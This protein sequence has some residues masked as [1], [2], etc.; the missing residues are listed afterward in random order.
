VLLQVICQDCG[1]DMALVQDDEV[2]KRIATGEYVNGSR[3]I[4]RKK[5]DGEQY[6]T[7]EEGIYGI[8]KKCAANARAIIDNGGAG[9]AATAQERRIQATLAL[10]RER[11][12]DLTLEQAAKAAVEMEFDPRNEPNVAFRAYLLEHAEK[13]E[14]RD[15]AARGFLADLDGPSVAGAA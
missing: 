5:F 2:E 8:C 14:A 3:L 12:S 7:P 6:T 11:R 9:A 1:K 15:E 4:K 10:I 13:D